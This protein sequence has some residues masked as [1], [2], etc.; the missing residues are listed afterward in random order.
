MFGSFQSCKLSEHLIFDN[1]D[2]GDDDD[3]DDDDND[4]DDDDE[5]WVSQSFLFSTFDSKWHARETTVCTSE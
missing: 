5:K 2:D 3:D 1:D 4:D